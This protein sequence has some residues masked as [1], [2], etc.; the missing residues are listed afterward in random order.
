M[1]IALVTGGNRGIGLATARRLAD[2]GTYVIIGARD[3]EAGQRAVDQLTGAGGKADWVGLDVTDA[4]SVWAAAH[5]LDDRFGK[6][7]ILVNNAGVLPE[8]TAAEEREVVDLGLFE[9]TFA[10]NVLGPITVLEAFLPLLRRS[11]A[12]RIVNVSSRMGSLADQTDQQSPYYG[13]VL[14]AYQAS[15][16]ALNSVTIGLSKAL[17][18]TSIKITSVCPGF[19]QTDLT[20]ISK[21]Q[22]PT[23]SDEAAEVVFRAATLAD[24]APSGTFVDAEGAVAW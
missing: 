6:L 22:A 20:P 19:V 11:V 24:Q 10:T 21:D 14:P 17:A 7:D 9:Q 16:A 3:P 23:T 18:D 12:G 13:M 1:N 5:Q 8:A 15:K 2:A 4:T